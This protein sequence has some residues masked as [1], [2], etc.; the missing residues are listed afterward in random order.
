MAG[1][2]VRHADI[3]AAI[4][5]GLRG[6]ASPTCLRARPKIR[7]EMV[8]GNPQ[9]VLGNKLEKAAAP[10]VKMSG[11]ITK[12]LAAQKRTNLFVDRN[13]A[14]LGGQDV[15]TVS[16]GDTMEHVAGGMALW[17]TIKREAWKRCAEI[18]AAR[19]DAWKAKAK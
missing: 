5:I 10:T 11:T 13:V 17:S 12:E 7:C 1:G 8:D 6:I 15:G 4:N 9:A 16:A 19:I 18:N 2:K 14:K 3:N